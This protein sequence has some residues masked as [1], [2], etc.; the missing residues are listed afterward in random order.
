M[1]IVH[2]GTF[3]NNMHFAENIFEWQNVTLP[4]NRTCVLQTW[5]LLNEN[6]A[7]AKFLYQ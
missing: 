6:I 7:S 3:T 1:T 4:S 2:H 5:C